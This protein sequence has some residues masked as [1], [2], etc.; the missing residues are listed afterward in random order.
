MCSAWRFGSSIKLND[1]NSAK[2]CSVLGSV[3]PA[4]WINSY[5][6]MPSYFWAK[7]SPGPTAKTTANKMIRQ[8]LQYGI[9]KYHSWETNEPNNLWVKSAANH[10][11]EMLLLFQRCHLKRRWAVWRGWQWNVSNVSAFPGGQSSELFVRWAQ[12]QVCYCRAV[13]KLGSLQLKGVWTVCLHPVLLSCASHQSLEI[14]EG[15]ITPLFTF[16][17]W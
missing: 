6:S 1:F 15:Q 10:R 14:W 5:E 4:I 7:Y 16:I 11:W 9:Q 3:F 12:K 13:V 2:G 17:K 8:R